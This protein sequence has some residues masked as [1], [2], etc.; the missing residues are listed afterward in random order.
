ML[1]PNAQVSMYPWK[2]VPE[3]IPLAVRHIRTFLKAN[4]SALAA[5]GAKGSGGL[6]G[7]AGGALDSRLPIGLLP[8]AAAL[9]PCA[10]STPWLPG[11]LWRQA[12]RPKYCREVVALASINQLSIAEQFQCNVR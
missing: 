10:T 12:P 8:T 2:D 7:V 9:P 4:R 1:A 11:K 5:I 6:S 3:K